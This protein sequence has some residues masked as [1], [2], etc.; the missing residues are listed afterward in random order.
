MFLWNITQAEKFV[1]EKRNDGI[2]T[3]GIIADPLFENLSGEN[4]T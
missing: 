1:A 3:N 4:F 2:E